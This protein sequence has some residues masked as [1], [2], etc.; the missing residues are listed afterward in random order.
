M[1]KSH[2]MNIDLPII[3]LKNR[4]TDKYRSVKD[5]SCWRISDCDFFFLTNLICDV[6]YKHLL[7]DYFSLK[8]D[9]SRIFSVENVACCALKKLIL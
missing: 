3:F 5:L 9:Y 4:L 6:E 8:Y 2:E 7:V 1:Q